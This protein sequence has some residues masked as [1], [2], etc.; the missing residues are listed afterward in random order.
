MEFFPDVHS[1][2]FSVYGSYSLI[3]VQNRS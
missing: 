3:D 1:M 2:V